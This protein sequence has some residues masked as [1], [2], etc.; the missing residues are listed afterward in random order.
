[1]A[2]VVDTC[3]LIDVL[4]DDPRFA[5]A[6]ADLLERLQPDGLEICPVTYAELAP[7]FDGLREVQDEFLHGVGVTLPADWSWID[8]LAAHAAW[9]RFIQHRRRHHLPRRPLADVLIGAHA[10]G[11]SGLATRNAQDFEAIF[12]EL[13]LAVPS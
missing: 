1:M 5:A 2:W 7:A 12:P 4:E 9:N 3:I 8:T 11:R 6:S 10:T 13:T